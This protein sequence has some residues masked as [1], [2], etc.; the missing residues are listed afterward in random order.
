MN[1]GEKFGG[2]GVPRVGAPGAARK[3][4][5]TLV[6]LKGRE[7]GGTEVRSMRQSGLSGTEYATLH[8]RVNGT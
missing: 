4:K 2:T 3:A 6:P 7:A 1:R 8:E 5:G